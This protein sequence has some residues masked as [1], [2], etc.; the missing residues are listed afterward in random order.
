MADTLIQFTTTAGQLVKKVEAK[1][2]R[3]MRFV[4]GTPITVKQYAGYARHAA[5]DL[6]T[7]RRD[8]P[9]SSPFRREDVDDTGRYARVVKHRRNEDNVSAVA[10]PF[11]QRADEMAAVLESENPDADLYR[12]AVWSITIVDDAPKDGRVISATHNVNFIEDAA[13]ELATDVA[14]HVVANATGYDD[15]VIVESVATAIYE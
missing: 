11:G 5:E 7:P 6:Q 12:M 13:D 14:E 15:I 9:A 8:E 4:D 2:G 3:L 1:D 10:F